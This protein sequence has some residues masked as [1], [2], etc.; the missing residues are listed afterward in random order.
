[1]WSRLQHTVR[2]TTRETGKFLSR[3][4]GHAR[5][6]AQTFDHMFDVGHRVASAVAPILDQH[7]GTSLAKKVR[8]GHDEYSALRA[9]IMGAHDHGASVGNQ[10]AGALMKAVPEIRI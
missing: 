5:K 4:Y 7:S 10:L 9:R 8:A 2:H 1:M 6:W 3:T